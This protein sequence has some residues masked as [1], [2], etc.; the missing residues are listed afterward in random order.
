MI[1]RRAL[2]C[3][4]VCSAVT[5]PALATPPLLDK[6]IARAGGRGALERAKVLRWTGE[7]KI[8]IPGRDP[9]VIGVKATIRPF[10]AYRTDSWLL[11]DGPAKTN[12]LIIENGQGFIERAGQPRQPMPAAQFVHENAQYALYGLM[13]LVTLKDAKVTPGEGPNQLTVEH[14][15]APRTTLTFAP[16][17]KLI[18]AAN[19]VPDPDGKAPIAQLMSFEGEIADS[20]VRWPRVLKIAE[21]GQP[22]FELTLASFGAAPA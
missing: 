1:H 22:Y 13:R 5:G 17:G 14:P 3:T 20:G 2:L 8:L 15:K 11:K 10:E 16:D 19:T 9:I 4:L 6:A 12:A 7:A 18:A 21:N